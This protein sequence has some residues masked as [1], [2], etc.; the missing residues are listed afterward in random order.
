MRRAAWNCENG[1][2]GSNL[3]LGAGGGKT[4]IRGFTIT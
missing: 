2:G 4:V 3:C 1:N